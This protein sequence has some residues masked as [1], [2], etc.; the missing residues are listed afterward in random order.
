MAHLAALNI[1]S[2]GMPE[3][4]ATI[5]GDFL[6]YARYYVK[7][8]IGVSATTDFALLFLLIVIIIIIIIIVV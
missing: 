4:L 7:T 1:Q 2:F 6:E 5:V 8:R 3:E